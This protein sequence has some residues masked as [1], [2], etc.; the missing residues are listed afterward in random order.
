MALIANTLEDFIQY[1]LIPYDV[2]ECPENAVWDANDVFPAGK[3]G[4]IVI[5]SDVHGNGT[6]IKNLRLNG[7][8]RS[9]NS[10]YTVH[11][12]DL[13]IIDFVGNFTTTDQTQYGMFEGNFHLQRCRVSAVLNSSYTK[14]I[15]WWYNYKNP[16]NEYAASFCSFNIDAASKYFQSICANPAALYSRIELHIPN[17]IE[18]PLSRTPERY[19]TETSMDSEYL[20][21]APNASGGINPQQLA[22]C[23]IHG[24]MPNVTAIE[25][26]DTSWHADMGL[27]STD[28]MPNFKPI[29]PDVS[30]YFL[31][32]TD[33]QLRDPAYLRSIGFPIAIEG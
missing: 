11:V 27:F 32:V 19:F 13:N 22:G 31:G 15:N 21:F 8:F 29:K 4:H 25:P 26:D 3:N 17:G 24:E 18:S 5:N 7:V 33:A 16:N 9:N 12:Q 10:R 30:A 1:A 14:I 20:I 2:I 23:I 28:G 6:T